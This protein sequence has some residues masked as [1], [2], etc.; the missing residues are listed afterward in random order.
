ML[1][2]PHIFGTRE[3]RINLSE[4]DTNFADAVA[5]ITATEQGL[6]AEAARTSLG[7]MV[8]A[9]QLMIDTTATGG[10]ASL[11]GKANI[12]AYQRS[13]HLGADAPNLNE[14]QVASYTLVLSDW[15]PMVTVQTNSSSATTIVIPTFAT[16]PFPV[17]CRIQICQWGTGITTVITQAGVILRSAASNQLRGQ[18]SLAYLDMKGTNEWLLS[19]D[20]APSGVPFVSVPP[21]I[22]GSSAAG[23]TLT[24]TAGTW[25][26]TPAPTV[27][28]Q[29]YAN[30]V[31]IGGQTGATYAT[32]NPG[33]AGKSITYRE[34][35]TNTAG[36]PVTALS[37]AIVVT[38][39]AATKPVNSVLPVVTGTAVVG[40]VLTASAGTWS[41]S[42][43]TYKYVWKS[44]GITTLR[45]S[46]FIAGATDTYTL[47]TGEGGTTVT[48]TVTAHNASGDTDVPATSIGTPVSGVPPSTGSSFPTID[49]ADGSRVAGVMLTVDTGVWLNNP[50]FS[51]QWYRS[52]QLSDVLTPIGT[53]SPNYTTTNADANTTI[54]CDLTGTTTGGALTVNVLGV[55]ITPSSG[56]PVNS[57]APTISGSTPIGSVLTATTGTWSN[58]PSFAY[59]WKRGATNVG[60]NSSTYTTVSA[61]G[62]SVMT[63]VVTATANSL[64]SSVTSSNSITV[65][66]AG[67][68]AL[69]VASSGVSS[70]LALDAAAA[71]DWILWPASTT[72]EKKSGGGALIGITA[73]GHTPSS[74]GGPEGC[75]FTWTGG[76]PT[77]SGSTDGTLTSE[78]GVAAAGWD[79]TFPV[80]TADRVI[81]VYMQGYN[82]L[83]TVNASLSDSSATPVSAQLDTPGGGASTTRYRFNVRAASAAQTLTVALRTTGTYGAGNIQLRAAGIIS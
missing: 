28:G 2:V 9:V 25:S 78:W 59:Q 52:D 65:D 18:Y 47:T 17:G 76:T 36:G 26:G 69:S 57:V 39:A 6:V 46:G 3:G 55:F 30:G 74:Y 33:D 72:P 38:A 58:S 60:T 35:A 8:P 80:G 24:R 37:N 42:P 14:Q 27:T 64:T 5:A 23:S 71:V 67:S 48:V 11:A 49:S 19:G 63:C 50:T 45:D 13:T 1:P 77:A 53:N 10:A 56:A 62:G 81:D 40:N 7:G 70:P 29:W 61:D 66:S 83:I 79:I 12:D 82:E 31:A 44:N 22:A 75:T 20:I 43:T 21:S 73:V 34:S 41:N 16:V 4:L 15:G 54:S 32:A 68:G 51:Y